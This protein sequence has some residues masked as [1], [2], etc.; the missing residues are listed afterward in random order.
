MAI[1]TNGHRAFS[2]P[3][4]PRNK[5]GEIDEKNGKAKGTTLFAGTGSISDATADAGVVPEID[6]FTGATST[7]D[8]TRGLVPQP[9]SHIEDPLQ[10]V[11]DNLRYLKGDGTW[12]DIPISRFSG[13]KST[14][15]GVS[16][17]GNTQMTNLWVTDTLSTQ[18]LNVTGA[19][20]FW[21]LVIDKV[22]A[23]GGNLLITPGSFYVDDVSGDYQG[24]SSS[25]TD[26][27]LVNP[28]GTVLEPFIYDETE[29]TGIDGFKEI[30]QACNITRFYLRTCWQRQA[31]DAKHI[32]NEIKNGDMIRCKTFNVENESQLTAN[33]D[34]WTFVV[35]VVPQ[36]VQRYH[37]SEQTYFNQIDL[38]ESFCVGDNYDVEY[39]I[40]TKCYCDGYIQLPGDPEH[41]VTNPPAHGITSF[42]FGYGGINVAVGDNLVVLGHLWEGD[43][44][45]AILISAY[46][47]LDTEVKAPAICQYKNIN[48]FT[49]LSGFRL[50]QIAANGNVFH[51][52]FMVQNGSGTIDLNERLNMFYTDIQTGLETVGIHLDGDHSTIKL[53]GSVE[54]RQNG[55]GSIDTLTVWDN[56][57]VMKVR[58]SPEAIPSKSSMA[59]VTTPEYKGTF[60]TLSNNRQA[61]VHT[62]DGEHR[63]EYFLWWSWDD[64]WEYWTSG[65]YFSFNT[66]CSLGTLSNGNV[67]SVNGL[68]ASILSK[69][70]WKGTT[71]VSDRGSNRQS[72]SKVIVRLQYKNN[73]NTW[74][75]I[76]NTARDILSSSTI[77]VLNESAT[78]EYNNYLWQDYTIANGTHEYRL[79]LEVQYNVYADIEFTSEQS[80]PYFTFDYSMTASTTIQKPT[81]SLM[82]I[83]N[84]GLVFN[85][86]GTKQWFYAGND[87]LEMCWGNDAL[88]S[89]DSTYGLKTSGK[90]V[91]YGDMT[92]SPKQIP[93][94]ADIAWCITP[95]SA[96]TVKLPNAS[97]YGVGRKLLI[98][99]NDYITVQT[100]S[101]SQKITTYPNSVSS[102]GWQ[103]SQTPPS[104]SASPYVQYTS[105]SMSRTW[106]SDEKTE[107]ETG[108]HYYIYKRSHDCL[109]E[110]VCTGTGWLMTTP[111]Y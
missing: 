89:L 76:S 60:I 14:G 53:V 66:T 10:P 63:Y 103:T 11:N 7:E 78:I 57:N 85:G 91:N 52:H 34:Y 73:S 24:H 87:G 4:L 68:K 96:A 84:N 20:H 28:T 106:K 8:G 102:T 111:H 45:D 12:S 70:Y 32:T 54:I 49:N 83:G 99:G 94:N 72:I 46:D 65:N 47:P 44:Q 107:S 62:I 105:F 41:T 23:A 38:F 40:G 88:I 98:L 56:D 5:Y 92:G 36:P 58:V 2:R 110:L 6:D 51:G 17:N 109:V 93:S 1:V 21:E 64:V 79:K 31:E 74:V 108:D 69:A 37:G 39:P 43:R 55:D 61:D 77:T 81:T 18:T 29:Q 97:T 16:I 3:P 80:S 82:Q 35:H 48:T 100:Y 15:D 27:D 75:E 19:A 22:R 30:L 26:L 104:A 95:T 50:N 25:Y 9:K 42:T 59:N 33:K 13:L 86:S 101:S 67:I 71:Y 90:L